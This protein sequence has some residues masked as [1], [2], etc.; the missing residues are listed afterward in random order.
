MASNKEGH[1]GKLKGSE[2]EGLCPSHET[3]AMGPCYVTNNRCDLR[4]CALK[5]TNTCHLKTML[6]MTNPGNI[7]F[8][9]STEEEDV[10]GTKPGD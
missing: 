10:L 9:N 5:L 3:E 1:F 8:I 2:V 6:T 4:R 7:C